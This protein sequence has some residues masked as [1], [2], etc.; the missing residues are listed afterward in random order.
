MLA[1][2]PASSTRRSHRWSRKQG[3]ELDPVSILGKA[4]DGERAELVHLVAHPPPHPFTPQGLSFSALR[5]LLP[6]P[7]P[8]TPWDHMKDGEGSSSWSPGPQICRV[9]ASSSHIASCPQGHVSGRWQGETAILPHLGRGP[10]L[11]LG[12]EV[13]SLVTEMSSSWPPR[14]QAAGRRVRVDR[15]G[16]PRAGWAAPSLSSPFPQSH[17][18][19]PIIFPDSILSFGAEPG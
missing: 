11:T 18:P 7:K 15:Q 1:S 9:E 19:F 5:S 17:I 13:S 3:R 8:L 10:G 14:S 6:S 4:L 12:Q 16:G 2:P